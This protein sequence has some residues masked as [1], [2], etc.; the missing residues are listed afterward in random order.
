[1]FL[2]FLTTSRVLI[3]QTFIRG[4]I[5]VPSLSYIKCEV[6]RMR[7]PLFI[8]RLKQNMYK[9]YYSEYKNS[10]SSRKVLE[11]PAATRK[12]SPK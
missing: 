12:R 2:F 1:M 6:L 10:P 7:R 9:L 3:A 11:A 8:H 5:S 4:T